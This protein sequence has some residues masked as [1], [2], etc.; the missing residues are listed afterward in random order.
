M[1][2]ARSAVCTTRVGSG[3]HRYKFQVAVRCCITS[4]ARPRDKHGEPRKG[5]RAANGKSRRQERKTGGK[6]AAD[7]KKAQTQTP[8]SLRPLRHPQKT[9]TTKPR[10]HGASPGPP[11]LFSRTI[12]RSVNRFP[13]AFST[14]CK[15]KQAVPFQV[16]SPTYTWVS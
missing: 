1:Q 16:I 11:V 12:L 14:F 15:D 7:R 10:L 6:K 8:I 13:F 5:P 9:H 2:R 3:L 4:R